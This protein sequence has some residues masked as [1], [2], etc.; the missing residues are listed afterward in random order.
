MSKKTDLIHAVRSLPKTVSVPLTIN[1]QQIEVVIQKTLPDEDRICFVKK[2]TD[3]II[4]DG[5]RC[6]ALYESEFAKSLIYYLT[7]L[8]F[9][10]NEKDMTTLI[11]RTELIE[12]IKRE[13]PDIVSSLNIA[14]RQQIQDAQETEVAIAAAFVRPDPLDRI[15]DAV[16]T[17]LDS[18]T[19]S[20]GSIDP[21]VLSD[22]IAAIK[23][24]DIADIVLSNKKDGGE[25]G[26]EDTAESADQP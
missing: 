20:I 4:R 10:I 11:Q 22:L 26:T 14:C 13:N 24:A 2:V 15:A 25:N 23:G 6:Y 18:M 9:T 3:G 17:F 1:G 8:C 19:D 12:L 5:K 7:D 21:S 16:E